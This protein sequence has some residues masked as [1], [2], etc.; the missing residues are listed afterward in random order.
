MYIYIAHVDGLDSLGWIGSA[1]ARKPETWKGGDITLTKGKAI[2][3]RATVW[4]SFGG[5]RI[6]SNNI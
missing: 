4:G 3:L 2:V 5:C 1:G 6:P